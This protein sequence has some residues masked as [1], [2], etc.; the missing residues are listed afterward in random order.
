MGDV[1]PGCFL[2][3]VGGLFVRRDDRHDP[4]SGVEM[5]TCKQCMMYDVYHTCAIR[6]IELLTQRPTALLYIFQ[7][8]LLINVTFC[9]PLSSLAFAGH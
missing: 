2:G 1:D 9:S 4:P 3:W 6:F 8:N 7:N 5:A